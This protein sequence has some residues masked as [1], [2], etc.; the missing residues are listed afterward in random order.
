MSG[1]D[2]EY[3]P[4]EN[5]Y[6]YSPSAP[7]LTQPSRNHGIQFSSP[8]ECA[9]HHTVKRGPFKSHSVSVFILYL[10]SVSQNVAFLFWAWKHNDDFADYFN[11]D[12][13]NKLTNLFLWFAFEG[14]FCEVVSV[15]LSL[16][17][18]DKNIIPHTSR[19]SIIFFSII[20]LIAFLGVLFSITVATY[21]KV[22]PFALWFAIS[23]V[24]GFPRSI[25]VF[26]V[27]NNQPLPFKQ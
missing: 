1:R 10:L 6:L 20:E 2:I 3:L 25:M 22:Y 17:L 16:V 24:F 7:L 23:V 14:S 26:T 15:C 4:S 12:K 11:G 9:H 13:H 21:H 19:K 8:T 5:P 18:L 27:R